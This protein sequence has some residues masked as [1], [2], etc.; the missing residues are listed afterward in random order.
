M[1]LGPLRDWC[2]NCESAWTGGCRNPEEQTFC[3]VCSHPKTGKIRGW[4]WRPHWLHHL[5]VTRHNFRVVERL[6]GEHRLRAE[7]AMVERLVDLLKE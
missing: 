4:V 3:V 7:T 2:P 5:L 1:W 6:I